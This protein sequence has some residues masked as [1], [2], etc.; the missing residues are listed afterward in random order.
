MLR[1][2]TAFTFA[3]TLIAQQ[4]AAPASDPRPKLFFHEDWHGT[5]VPN[6]HPL[7]PAD[8]SSPNL[9]FHIYGN[10]KQSAKPESGVWLI[11]H[12]E[13]TVDPPYVWNAICEASCAIT[14]RDKT[15]FV[16]LSSFG[17]LRWVTKQSGFHILHPIV[18]L[19][20][21]TWLIA[22]HGEPFSNNWRETE[23]S[24]ADVRWRRLDIAKVA[25]AQGKGRRQFIVGVDEW[26]ENPDLSRVDEIGFTDLM[27]GAGRTGGGSSRIGMVEVYG[28]PVPR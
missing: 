23:V 11:L 6:E 12:A 5:K 24:F 16:D 15:N 9:E 19:A 7:S 18:K 21:G 26:V 14:L 2:L 25:E 22:D 20:D 13:P 3:A 28:K 1:Y 27:P 8:L 17:K 4:P 10:V